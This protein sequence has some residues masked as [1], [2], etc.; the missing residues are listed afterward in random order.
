M[1]G[2]NLRKYQDSETKKSSNAKK[3]III[4]LICCLIFVILYFS[5]PK[6]KALFTP[7]ETPVTE[8][9]NFYPINRA[10]NIYDDKVYMQ[11][12]R[13]FYFE[14]PSY[15]TTISFDPETLEDIPAEYKQ[16]VELLTKYVLAAIEGNDGK[17]EKLLSKKF[18]KDGFKAK[19]GF[20]AQKIYETKFSIY[21]QDSIKENGDTWQC[22]S[23]WVS[24]KI[25]QNNG[26][27]R[28]DM[29]SDCSRKELFVITYRD[30][31]MEIDGIT[32]YRTK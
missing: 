8:N 31:K 21:E 22:W 10:E 30:G 2:R 12:D 25:R 5:L 26:T 27:F 3:A 1:S 17:I 11:L 4:T 24:Y 15:G 18:F 32:P 13:G 9:Y 23:F 14:D 29:G 6:L 7:K 20:T 16:P 19:Y 28:D